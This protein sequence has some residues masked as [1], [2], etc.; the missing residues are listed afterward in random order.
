MSNNAFLN[1]T[2][3]QL[4]EAIG[5][6]LNGWVD[7][8]EKEVAYEEGYQQGLQDA[9]PT[10]P[11]IEALTVTENGTYTAPSGVHGYNPVTVNVAASGGNVSIDGLPV[12]YSRAG[13]IQFNAAQIVDTR[14]V[15]NQNTKIRII[16][17]R[18]STASMYLYGVASSGNTASVTA[19]MSGTGAWRFGNTYKNQTVSSGDRIH[20][21]TQAVSSVILNGTTTTYST[22]SD[23]E[24]IGSLLIGACRSS[25]GAVGEAQFIGKVL[26]VEIWQGNELAQKLTPLVNADGVYRFYDIVTE[27]FFDS[28]TDTALEGG[29]L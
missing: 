6:V 8:S 28:I 15:C 20:V 14:I 5:K 11:V 7:A 19:Y 17:T 2:T 4:D 13:Y 24:T 29:S 23:F 3:A 26:T 22:I 9:T 21:A 16:F 1:Y 12:G 18:E 27:T 25:S 10:E